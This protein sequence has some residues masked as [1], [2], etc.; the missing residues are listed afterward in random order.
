MP[1]WRCLNDITSYCDGTPPFSVQPVQSSKGLI[2]GKCPADPD[3]CGQHLTWTESLQ[4]STLGANPTA[5]TVERRVKGT[6]VVAKAPAE[7]SEQ[8]QLGLPMG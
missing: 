3:D 8:E 7:K 2:G 1:F 6:K 5:K 4:K